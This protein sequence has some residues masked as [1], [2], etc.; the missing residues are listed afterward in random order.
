MSM[1]I[2]ELNAESAELLSG[3]EALS[4]LKF[5][6]TKNIAVTKH[7]ANVGATNLSAAVNYQS[8]G[9]DAESAAGQSITIHQ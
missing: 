3:R 9:A 5:N 1:N 6:F 2:D 8:W 4:T 7:V